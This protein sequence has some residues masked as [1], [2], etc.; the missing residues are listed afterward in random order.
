MYTILLYYKYVPIA[1]AEKF[2]KDQF[3]LCTELDLKGRIIVSKE[4]INGTVEGKAENT[5]KYITAMHADER[6]TDIDFKE[7]PGNGSAFPRLSVK[8]RAE[9]VTLGTGTASKNFEKGKYVE[10]SELQGWFD[11]NKDFVVVD[12]RNEYEHSVGHFENSVRLPVQNFREI[13]QAIDA[14]P[15]LQDLKNK[16]VISVCT[17]GVRCEKATSMLIEKGFK[18]VRQLHGGMV[19]YLEKFPGKKFK[20]SLYV[21]DNRVVVNYDSPEN[22]SVVGSCQNCGVASERCVNCDYLDCHGHFIVCE[23]CSQNGIFCSETCRQ[24]HSAKATVSV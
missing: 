5:A 24:K 22:H 19:R 7:S 17:G 14:L 20:G 16:T 6:F 18:D 12:M 11:E 23:A 21:F 3:L 15:E 1:D 10:P 4:G 13:P 2:R 8:N 9:I